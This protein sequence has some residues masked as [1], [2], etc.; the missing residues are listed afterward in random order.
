MVKTALK[1]I[2]RLHQ[3]RFSAAK[4][5]IVTVKE[6]STAT[7]REITLVRGDSWQP[8]PHQ[9]PAVVTP[10]GLSSERKQYLYEKIRE[11][12]PDEKRTLY[13]LSL[14]LTIYAL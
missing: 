8:Y 9:L 10:N 1:G 6:S 14:E 7:K 4:R 11:F 3:F 5:G 2:S 13:V 12:C